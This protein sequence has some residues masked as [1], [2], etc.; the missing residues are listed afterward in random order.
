[1]GTMT[2]ACIG[3]GRG[4][5]SIRHLGHLVAAASLLVA[6]AV[7]GASRPQVAAAGENVSISVRNTDVAEIF[8][9]L[10]RTERTNILLAKGVAGDISVNL[11]D[12]PMD[13]AIHSIAEAAGYVVERRGASYVVLEQEDSG[14][15][16]ASGLTSVQTLP[17]HYSDPETVVSV[18]RNHLSP[19]GKITTLAARKLLVVEDQPEFLA[20][21]E[22]LLPEIDAMPTQVF[23]EGKILEIT[24]SDGEAFGVDWRQLLTIDGEEGSFGTR[25]LSD[26]GSAGLFVDLVTPHLQL[27][28]DTLRSTGR[29][30]TLS[31]PRLLALENE[32][33]S[34][35]VGD[36]QGFRVTTTINQ[37][38]TESIEFLESGVILRVTPSVDEAGRIMMAIHPEVSTGNITDGIP[39]QTTTEVTTRLVAEDGQTIFIGG[40]IKNT[41]NKSRRGV[42]GLSRIPVL[43]RLFS[44][45]DETSVKTETVV[46]V[47]PHVVAEGERELYFDDLAKVDEAE[48]EARVDA[49]RIDAQF[50]PQPPAASARPDDDRVAPVQAGAVP[51][52]SA[53][54]E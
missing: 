9:M 54:D 50:Q 31:T 5:S 18:L 2:P 20:R 38:T 44:R 21:I 43:G 46:M 52:G 49:E 39:A 40:L 27:A 47:T 36:R 34:V 41:R 37:V 13:V 53:M 6:M 15:N 10:A 28:L 26:P 32:E 4:S 22:R 12:V 48:R 1:M 24:L 8:E 42:P 11:Y 7:F 45:T 35:I 25:L 16:L 14:K 3:G 17:V 19:Y 23:I 29:V 51:D 30:R 33:A